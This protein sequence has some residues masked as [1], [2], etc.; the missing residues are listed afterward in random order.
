MR[1]FDTDILTQ[2]LRGSPAY[3]ERLARIPVA[4]QA[5]PIVAAEEMLRGRLNTI[6]QAEAGKAKLS[7]EQAY[8]YFEQTLEDMR[9]LTV[10]SYTSQADAHYEAWRTQKLRGSTHD[11]RI[12]AI[13]VAHSVTLVTRNR[14]D[15]ERI[16]GLSLEVWE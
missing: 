1:A 3:A 11:L 4:D 13:C 2:I 6:R 9:E 8:Q 15:F 12:A 14:R 5:I 10:L 16:P 7:I